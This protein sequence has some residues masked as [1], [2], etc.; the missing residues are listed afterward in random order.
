MPEKS[1]GSR[2]IFPRW[3]N[4]VVPLVLI[5][6]AGGVPYK[7]LLVG[8]IGA[9]STTDVGYQPVQ[10]IPYSHELHVNQLGMDCRYCHTTV[11]SSAFAAIPSANLCMNCH[12]AIRKLNPAGEPNPKLAALYKAYDTGMPIEWVKVHDLPDYSYFNHSAHINRGVSCV[13]CHD[14]VDQMG[15]E[16]VLQ[17]KELSM[18]WCLSCHRNPAPNLR[19]ADQIMNLGWGYGKLT[20]AEAAE[21]KSLGVEDAEAGTK[22]TDAQRQK[23]GQA[24]FDME[25]I[26]NPLNMSDCSLCHR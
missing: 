17:A 2:F 1:S 7:V 16:G 22:L 3:A 15:P 24:V 23:V 19:P 18:G 8:L 10:P 20:E 13:M 9:P 5:A 11:E 12:H 25:N 21:I 6:L 4:V 26:R 14:R